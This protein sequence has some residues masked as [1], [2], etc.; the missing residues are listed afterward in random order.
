MSV[1]IWML[2][3]FIAFLLSFSMNGLAISNILMAGKNITQI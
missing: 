2:L 1:T 3:T